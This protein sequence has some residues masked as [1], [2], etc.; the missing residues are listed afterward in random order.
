M[1]TYI[2]SLISLPLTTSPS[3][4]SRLS[5][6]T[7]LSSLC[8]IADSLYLSILLIYVNAIFS[9]HPTFSFLPH[10]RHRDG[11]QTLEKLVNINHH[12]RN[13]NQHYNEVSFLMVRMATIK[14]SMNPMERV[15]RKG[16]PP[17]LLVG[18]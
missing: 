12:Q 13:A 15:W 8:Y 11:Q 17:A 14:K 16:N 2:L 1:Y 5:Q 3:H 4:P 10:S 7:T 9:V 6:S 18:M